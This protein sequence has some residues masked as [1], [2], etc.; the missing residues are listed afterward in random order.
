MYR[1]HG[2]IQYKSLN[3]WMTRGEILPSFVLLGTKTRGCVSLSSAAKFDEKCVTASKF[4]TL[5]YV[6]E[7][8]ES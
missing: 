6:R 3:E 2:I 5:E 7:K 8:T 1:G 4:S